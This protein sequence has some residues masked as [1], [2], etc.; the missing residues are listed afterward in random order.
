MIGS[1]GRAR[2]CC[3]GG[4]SGAVALVSEAQ[5]SEL[6]PHLKRNWVAQGPKLNTHVKR[7][8]GVMVCTC[9]PSAGGGWGVDRNSGAPWSAGIVNLESSRPVKRFVYKRMRKLEDVFWSP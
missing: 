3:W 7:K 2:L 8:L 6:N 1:F 9:I 4:C 5:V